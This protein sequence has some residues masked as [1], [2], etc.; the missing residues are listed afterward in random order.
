VV[1]SQV[2]KFMSEIRRIYPNLYV[3]YDYDEENDQYEIWHNDPKLEFED[4]EF[5][6]IVGKL[7]DQFLFKND[8]Y[9]FYFGYDH[10]KAK[11][12][13]EL[14]YNFCINKMKY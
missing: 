1:R 8:I 5:Q 4:D 6:T 13:K 12:L 14:E 11:S 3:A 10:K 7:V 2:Q 9:N